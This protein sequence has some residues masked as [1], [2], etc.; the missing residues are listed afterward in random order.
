MYPW[1]CKG[2]C[3]SDKNGMFKQYGMFSEVDVWFESGLN[4][5]TLPLDV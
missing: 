4:S 5:D 1:S 2:N 3:I